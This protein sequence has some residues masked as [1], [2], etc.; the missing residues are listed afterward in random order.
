[1]KGQKLQLNLRDVVPVAALGV[2]VGDVDV[3]S[4]LVAE[5]VEFSAGFSKATFDRAGGW[6]EDKI[7]IFFLFTFLNKKYQPLPPV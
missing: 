7:I 3:W 6:L 4:T 1:L 2:S 5:F